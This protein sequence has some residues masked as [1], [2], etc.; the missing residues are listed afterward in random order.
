MLTAGL[1]IFSSNFGS[2]LQNSF[3]ERV[4]YSVGSD[5]RISNLELQGNS[6]TYIPESL[7]LKSFG[8]I[9]GV[10]Q[11][12]RG[13]RAPAQALGTQS[14]PSIVMLSVD[15]NSFGDVGWFRKDFSDTSI[16]PLLKSLEVKTPPT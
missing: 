14:A 8:Q 16:T 3:K 12:S 10:D 7:L 1:G 11:L 2:T 13:L 15:T 5:I 4:L 9:E 6:S